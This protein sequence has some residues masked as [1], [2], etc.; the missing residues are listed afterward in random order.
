MQSTFEAENYASFIILCGIFEQIFIL[1]LHTF[2][3]TSVFTHLNQRGLLQT[4]WGSQMV[5]FG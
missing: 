3:A 1:F 5:H 4:K 2:Y